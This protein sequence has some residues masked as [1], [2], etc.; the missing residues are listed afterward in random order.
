MN[1]PVYS[2]LLALLIPAFAVQI[3]LANPIE[4]HAYDAAA[5]HVY[6][7]VVFSDALRD[8]GLYPRWVMPIN[9]GLGGPLFSFYSPLSYYVMDALNRIGLPHP[10]AWRVFVALALIAA[11]SG[12]FALGLALFKRAD[13]AL[14]TAACF[15]YAPYLMRDFFERGAPQG[16]AI[17]LYPWLLWSL[18][19]L[20]ESPSGLRLSIAALIWAALLLMH[21]LSA[22]LLLP[23]LAI[24]CVFIAL[25]SGVKSLRTPGIALLLGLLLSAFH[26]LP[27]LVD[28]RYV[29][30]NSASGD[31]AAQPAAN[32]VA[33]TDLLALPAVFDT[34]I[35]NNTSSYGVGILHALVVL[36]GVGVTF[37]LY[38]RKRFA[39][40][41]LTGSL[42]LFGLM[43]LW[44]QLDAASPIWTAFPALN[45][46][47]FRTRLLNTTGLIA[48]ILIGYLLMQITRHWSVSIL[49][50]LLIAAFVGA[51]LP[52]LYPQLL[53]RYMSFPPA[54]TV[55][56]AQAWAIQN[57]VPGLTLT[58]TMELIPRWRR[59]IFTDDEVA[60]ITASP[61]DN[62]PDG[63]HILETTRHASD[64]Q[65]K[66]ETPTAFNAALHLMYF[67]GWKC[68]LNGQA[69][70]L[71]PMDVSG[72]ALLDVPAGISTIALHYEGTDAQ[73][74]GDLITLVSVLALLIA[75]GGCR[76][77]PGRRLHVP[78]LHP[79]RHPPHPRPPLLAS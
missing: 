52:S 58:T 73:H 50:I 29:Q 61:I 65:I 46:L 28:S 8:G 7:A 1:R 23:I 16:A 14:V 13:V 9:G 70:A 67:P 19:R 69:Q 2:W 75:A 49:S 76:S 32:P 68:Y 55:A 15:P 54:P 17:A 63:A 10:V 51:E 38:R 48:A 53:H 64:L 77:K 41:L 78:F 56:D 57:H 35:D 62:L 71:R 34:G 30:L 60:K 47:Q 59:T 72:Y 18:L 42:S 44:M 43:M 26:V 27:F 24:F 11:S 12:M 31:A 45:I 6:R 79:P 21:N 3:A 33:L 74:A 20:S 66:V 22:L 40:A 37:I 39:E 4:E 5:F 36:A 25:R